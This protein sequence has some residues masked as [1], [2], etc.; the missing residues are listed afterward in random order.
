MPRTFTEMIAELNTALNLEALATRRLH[1]RSRLA[2]TKFIVLARLYYAFE[3]VLPQRELADL[4]Q[5]SVSQVQK[6]AVQLEAENLLVRKDGAPREG[7]LVVLTKKGCERVE[8]DIKSGAGEFAVFEAVWADDQVRGHA[9]VALEA[10]LQGITRLA[11]V[12]SRD[13]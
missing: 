5:M 2:R 3:H 1:R 6:V 9:R 8:A 13:A 7:K 12:R 10:A 4:L 11:H